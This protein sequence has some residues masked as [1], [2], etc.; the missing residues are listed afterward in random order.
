[1]GSEG[2]W[3]RKEEQKE[4]A[5]HR[6]VVDLAHLPELNNVQVLL[7]MRPAS[8]TPQYRLAYLSRDL[9]CEVQY[10]LVVYD[11]VLI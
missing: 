11:A 6:C 10:P 3:F 9:H 1:M 7:T 5:R 4:F 8:G 2:Q